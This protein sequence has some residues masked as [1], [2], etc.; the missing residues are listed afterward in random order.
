[1]TGGVGLYMGIMLVFDHVHVHNVTPSF[2]LVFDRQCD[3]WFY[4]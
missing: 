4:F 1:M 3:Q 2:T